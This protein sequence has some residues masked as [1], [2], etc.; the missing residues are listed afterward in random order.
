MRNLYLKLEKCEFSK[1][2]IKI[3][4]FTFRQNRTLIN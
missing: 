2:E 4:D 3:L 1:E